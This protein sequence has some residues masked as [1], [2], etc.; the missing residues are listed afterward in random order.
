MACKVCAV[1]RAISTPDVDR[2]CR[3]CRPSSV[4]RRRSSTLVASSSGTSSSGRPRRPSSW[5]A[6]EK[7]QKNIGRDYL[8]ELGKNDTGNTNTNVGARQ[9]VVDDVFTRNATGEFQLGADSDIASGELRY[10]YQEA[11]KFKN[12]VGDYHCPPAF[13][14]KVSGHLVK[15]FLFGGGL[16]HVREMTNEAGVVVQPPNTPLILGVWGGKGCGKSFNL[17]LACKAMGVT[18]IITS[19]GELE[20]ENA[21]A[22]GRLIRERYKRAGEILRRTGV[23]S[24]LIINDVDAGIGWFKDTQ[25]TVNNQT[26][27]GTLMNLCDHPELVSLGEDRGE[28]GKN[29]QTA[30]V[31]IIVTGNDLSTVYAPLLRDGRMDKWY[32]N[33]S[34]DD[35]CD[36][37]HA[38]FKD[39]VDWSPD[40]TARLVN[41][42]PGQPLDFFGAARA[43]VYDDAV[44]RWM[45]EVDVRERCEFLIR[46]MSLGGEEDLFGNVGDDSSLWRYHTPKEV[47]RGASIS[48]QSVFDAATELAQQQ[49]YMMTQKLSIEYMKWQ[50]NPEDL[51]D[52]E[53]EA[54]EAKDNWRK[55][56]KKREEVRRARAAEMRINKASP[57]SIEARRL[58]LEATMKRAREKRELESTERRLT[59]TSEGIQ[60]KSIPESPSSKRWMTV[61]VEEAFDAFKAGVCSVI[62]VR[63]VKSFRRESISG[64]LNIPLVNI[65]GKP[66]AYTYT[67][68][69]QEF[70][71]VFTSKF[72]NKD[73]AV[74]LLGGRQIEANGLDDPERCGCMDALIDRGYENVVVV[75]GGYDGWV[76]EYTPGGKKRLQEWKL[77]VVVGASGTSCVGAELPVVGGLA[78]ERK[79]AQIAHLKALEEHLVNSNANSAWKVA[80]D[81]FDRLYFYNVESEKSQWAD[82]SA[83]DVT[84]QIWL[85]SAPMSDSGAIALTAISVDDAVQ[86]LLSKSS[87]VIDVRNPYAFNMESVNGVINVPLRRAEGSKLSP[88][89]AI[90]GK[91]AFAQALASIAA[92]KAQSLIF[93]GDES[94]D[95][96][97]EIAAQHALS[98]GYTDVL[99]VVDSVP[100][101]LK[102]YTAS[103]KPKKVLAQGAYKSDLLSKGAFN[104][105]A[106][107]S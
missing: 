11:R 30:R 13:M 56:M 46:K 101:W 31:P 7:T 69:A 89:Y 68:N 86:R 66:L 62:D 32:W 52:E 25:H 26:V 59:V 18:P 53:R 34:R 5:T 23:M 51:T 90:V 9:G 24:C 88:T 19:A 91:D 87:M 61:S 97:S 17:E 64:A 96:R 6:R 75:D 70:L 105:F 78:E 84:N 95:E 83:Y 71:E 104:M 82:P 94:P 76:K 107:E 10:R 79:A 29:L 102:K 38:L 2:S 39:E 37:V 57:E 65:E 80:F 72:P 81:R 92:D 3:P 63:D 55:T 28:D 99:I 60:S 49:Q 12:L 67:T 15:N 44:S 45:C 100:Q 77:D 35:I 33:P 54:M 73:A 50:K 106:G 27:C 58:L 85:L 22:P 43:K 74:V 36:I 103:G 42:F 1:G 14:E 21:G 20:D 40:A 47:V 8:V 4:R 48:P 16:R 41:A 98:A 93:V